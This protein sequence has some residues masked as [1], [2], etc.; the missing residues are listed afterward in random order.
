MRPSKKLGQVFL[1]SKSVLREIIESAELKKTDTVLEIGPGIGALT[2]ELAKKVKRVVAVEKDLKMIDV[3]KEA[4]R[5]FKNVKII[6]GDILKADLKRHIL[7]TKPYKVVANLPYYITSPVIRKFLESEN[8]PSQMILMV[9]KEVAQRIVAHPPHMSVLAVSVQ[10]YAKPKIISSV[11][12]KCFWPQPKI[13]SAIIKISQIGRNLPRIDTNLFFEIVRAGFSHPRKQLV[14]N[15]SI[16]LKLEKQK[17]RS[18]LLK[19]KISPKRVSNRS[20]P[21]PETN[22]AEVI[23]KI[24]ILTTSPIPP[25]VIDMSSQ[26]VLPYSLESVA[27]SPTDIRGSRTIKTLPSSK[28]NE[29]D[30]EKV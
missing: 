27:T 7:N 2:Q 12:K 6:E 14:N 10:F 24:A 1:I 19:N 18:W 21:I 23:V 3:L 9:Q 25:A 4:L 11:S 8:P 20:S 15:L 28:Y 17:T 30:I 22:P 16:G 5:D 26:G 13:D 29:K